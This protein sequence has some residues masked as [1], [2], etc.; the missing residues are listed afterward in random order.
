MMNFFGF[1][2][3]PLVYYPYL[4]I[5][6]DLLFQQISF[7]HAFLVILIGHTLYFLSVIVPSPQFGGPDLLYFIKFAA[8]FYSSFPS[9]LVLCC[10]TLTPVL[11]PCSPTSLPQNDEFQ[12]GGAGPWGGGSQHQFDG[13]GHGQALGN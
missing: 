13:W 7:L 2:M 11:L 5:A 10:V 1:L 12:H 6:L 9:S 4:M 3:I 8:P